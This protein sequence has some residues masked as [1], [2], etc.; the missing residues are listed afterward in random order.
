MEA[1]VEAEDAFLQR[2]CACNLPNPM[3]K[4]ERA[5]GDGGRCVSCMFTA[6]A[7]SGW[8]GHAEAPALLSLRVS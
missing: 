5:K 4:R 2:C 8:G 7:P 1:L 6:M 3:S